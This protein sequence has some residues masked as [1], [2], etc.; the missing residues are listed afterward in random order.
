MKNFILIS[1]IFLI[2]AI[3][4]SAQNNQNIQKKKPLD[5]KVDLNPKDSLK[6][7]RIPLLDSMNK[8]I[9]IPNAYKGKRQGHLIAPNNVQKEHDDTIILEKKLS[10][11]GSVKMPGTKKLDEHSMI[12]KQDTATVKSPIIKR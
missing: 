9:E 3:P 2:W 8:S 11:E 12:A 4:S 7:F 5:F 6:Q 10:G 1:F